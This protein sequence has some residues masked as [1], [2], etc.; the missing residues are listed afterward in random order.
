MSLTELAA[1]LEGR[2]DGPHA[3]E[4]TAAVAHLAAEAVRYLNYATGSHAGQGLE[5]PGT[6]YSIAGGLSTAVHRM[7][8]LFRQLAHELSGQYADGL[9]ATDDDGPVV[10]VIAAATLRLEEAEKLARRLGYEMASLQ[11]VLSG[12]NGRGPNRRLEDES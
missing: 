11:T 6:V 4:D 10:E 7:P 12:L 3:D 1:K 2:M 8:Q 5:W 9:L